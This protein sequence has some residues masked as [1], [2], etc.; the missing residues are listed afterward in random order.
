MIYYGKIA[1]EILKENLNNR[2]F[3]KCKGYF[4]VKKMWI[5]FDTTG[6]CWVEE[7]KTEVMAI[8]WLEHFYEISEI[9]E[10]EVLK[11]QRDLFF[12]PKNGFLRIKFQ[13]NT[14]TSKLHQLSA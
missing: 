6:D 5:A 9:E 4:L 11:I 2:H 14:V 7:F 8:C 1:S 12:I 10:F 3:N 13:S